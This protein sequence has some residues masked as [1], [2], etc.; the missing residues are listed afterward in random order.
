[1]NIQV[2]EPV[3][4]EGESLRPGDIIECEVPGEFQIGDLVI[5]LV[6]CQGLEVKARVASY[7]MAT[8]AGQRMRAEKRRQ[9]R[10]DMQDKFFHDASLML[11]LN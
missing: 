1:M 4:I 7:S 2:N 9:A 8:E 10:S 3:N 5:C 6:T 11:S